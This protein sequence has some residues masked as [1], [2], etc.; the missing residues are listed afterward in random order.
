MIN[1][2]ALKYLRRDI[3][4]ISKEN[5]MKFGDFFI[6]LYA[7]HSETFTTNQTIIDVPFGCETVSRGLRRMK[8]LGLIKMIKGGGGKNKSKAIYS[9]SGKGKMITQQFYIR[10]SQG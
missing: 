9:I 6:L 8:S 1:E 7:S 3:K 5:N 10:L 4:N 2:S